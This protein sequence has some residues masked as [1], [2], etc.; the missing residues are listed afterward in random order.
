[1]NKKTE[2]R[3]SRATRKAR[4]TLR[5]EARMVR[6]SMVGVYDADDNERE[7][8]MRLAAIFQTADLMV[9]WEVE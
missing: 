5:R 4:E 6:A 8:A 7:T 3:G 2:V 9:G 1:M